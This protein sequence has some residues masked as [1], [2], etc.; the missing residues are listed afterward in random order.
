MR[1]TIIDRNGDPINA[2]VISIRKTASAGVTIT[3]TDEK[4]NF[5]L[6]NLDP[7]DEYIL[8]IQLN[9]CIYFNDQEGRASTQDLKEDEL[10]REDELANEDEPLAESKLNEVDRLLAAADPIDEGEWAEDDEPFDENEPFDDDEPFNEDEWDNEDESL[11][12]NEPTDEE[13]KWLDESVDTYGSDEGYDDSEWFDLPQEQ[14]VVEKFAGNLIK[15]K[16]EFEDKL[17]TV[18]KYIW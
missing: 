8:K 16:K 10:A 7:D 5:I 6:Q 13:T 11:D 12:E 1:G 3:Q 18:R 15:P 17:Y 4:G 9:Q 2:A 14:E